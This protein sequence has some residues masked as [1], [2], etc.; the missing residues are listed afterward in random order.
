MVRATAAG[1]AIAFAEAD[2]II[3]AG[4]MTEP[5]CPLCGHAVGL[6]RY[7]YEDYQIVS[8]EKCALWRACPRLSPVQL[9]R[10]YEQEYYSDERARQGRYEA[11]RDA[12]LD[13]WRRSARLVRDEACGRLGLTPEQVHLLDV[14]CGQGFFMQECANLGLRVHGVEPSVHAVRYAR[15]ALKLDV[16]AGGCEALGSHEAYHVITLWEVLEHVPDPLATLKRLRE[17]LHPGGFIWVSVPNV[18]ALQRHVEGHDYFNL[19]NKSHLTHFDRRTL[20]QMLCRA[21]FRN[22]QRVV[23]FGG[24]GRNGLGAVAQYAARALCLGTD[25]RFVAQK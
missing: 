4:S 10:Y 6:V 3:A 23:H 5:V 2:R 12:N 25:L 16:R 1:Q 11:W 7:R 8:C 17:H 18:Q 9:E 21:G 20:R 19:R 24:G 22:V 15:Q 14:G 13:V